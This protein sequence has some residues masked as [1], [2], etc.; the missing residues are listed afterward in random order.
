MDYDIIVVGSGHNGLVAA[1]YLATAGK[2]VLVVERNDYFGGG[3]ATGEL[4]EPG[5][6]SE[7]HS[8]VHELIL[9]NPLIENDELGLL[10]RYGLEYIHLD[11]PYAAHFDDGT[12]IPIYR[13]RAATMAKIA[14]LSPRDADAYDQFMDKAAAVA[15]ALLPSLFVPPLPPAAA[16]SALLSTPHGAQMM[17]ESGKS[18]TG[19]YEDLFENPKVRLAMVRRAAEVLTVHPDD[20]STGL[21]AYAVAGRLERG[22]TAVPKGGG[23]SL[24]RALIACIE[25]HGGE[26]RHS[27]NVT[28]V[29]TRA[30]RAIGVRTGDGEDISAGDAVLAALHPHHLGEFVDGL[31]PELLRDARRTKSAPYSAFVVHA[32]L[33][34]PMRAKAGPELDRFIWNTLSSPDVTEMTRSF[35][36][37][38]RGRLPKVALVEAGCPTNVDPSR[39][40]DGHALLHMFSLSCYHLEDGGPSRWDQIKD[41]VADS[42][43]SRLGDFYD[44]ISLDAVRVRAIVTP[45]DHEKDTPSFAGGDLGGLAMYGNQL[46]GLRPTPELS[47]YAVPGADGLYLTGPFMHPGTGVGGGGRATAIRMF[48]DLKLDFSDISG[49]VDPVG[50]V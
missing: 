6:L 5:F 39:A 27:T 41:E 7:R 40:P 44:G 36:D 13:D 50:V 26:V 46:G 33:N 4:T 48:N 9:A 30:G 3:V 20:L 43:I 25:D 34:A 17:V 49:G 38:R 2:R 23:T 24:I 37:L 42:L 35:D 32:S 18:I 12:A 15:D 11:T 14:E 45:A 31:A 29:L 8:L 10:S 22:G 19:L 1:A 47:Q 21:F 28:K 16:A